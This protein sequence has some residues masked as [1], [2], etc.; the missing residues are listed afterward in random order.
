MKASQD[1]ITHKKKES[2]QNLFMYY[3]LKCQISEHINGISLR[4]VF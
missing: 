4:I 3:V 2:F 1:E